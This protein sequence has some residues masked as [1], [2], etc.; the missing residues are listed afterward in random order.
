MRSQRTSFFSNSF[1]NRSMLPR[2]KEGK[3]WNNL[4]FHNNSYWYFW[5]FIYLFI[6]IIT[7]REIHLKIQI[8]CKKNQLINF[9]LFVWVLRLSKCQF[10][11]ERLWQIILPKNSNNPPSL[12]MG[13]FWISVDAKLLLCSSSK[14]K[15]LFLDFLSEVLDLKNW[16][17]KKL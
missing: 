2:L 12:C 16:I 8:V 5:K 15:K 10:H 6:F 1:K 7:R 9:S 4:K 13:P 3:N 14:N 11:A 17:C